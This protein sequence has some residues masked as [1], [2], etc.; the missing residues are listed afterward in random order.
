MPRKSHSQHAFLRHPDPHPEE[1][2]ERSMPT[3]NPSPLKPELLVHSQRLHSSAHQCLLL[4][5]PLEVF[6]PFTLSFSTHS[7]SKRSHILY[8]SHSCHKLTCFLSNCCTMDSQ[9]LLPPWPLCA[10]T[11]HASSRAH[12]VSS[13]RAHITPLQQPS[14]LFIRYFS[15]HIMQGA[16]MF[17]LMGP[18]IRLNNSSLE[19]QSLHSFE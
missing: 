7:S 19:A 8:N 14:K 13:L 12:G 15:I 1:H 16:W 4:L 3:L 17:R 11:S 2:L 18:R 10:T 9:P 6:T 5:H